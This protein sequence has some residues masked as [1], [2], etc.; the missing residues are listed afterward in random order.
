MNL[1]QVFLCGFWPVDV[2]PSVYINVIDN[3]ADENTFVWY[4]TS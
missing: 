3:G 1:H 2:Y 4:Q